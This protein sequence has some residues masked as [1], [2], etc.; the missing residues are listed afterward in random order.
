M[1]FPCPLGVAEHP[2]I[3]FS[4][5]REHRGIAVISGEGISLTVPVT[6]VVR[7]TERV[8][9]T[10]RTRFS[11]RDTSVFSGHSDLTSVVP[12]VLR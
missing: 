1:C 10:S 8:A 12:T 7:A 6:R 3:I 9:V 11:G 4:P 5:Q 2:P